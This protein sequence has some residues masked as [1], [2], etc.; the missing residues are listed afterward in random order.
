MR[1]ELICVEK[2]LLKLV[3]VFGGCVNLRSRLKASSPRLEHP[4]GSTPV[5]FSTS[6]NGSSYWVVFNSS[7]STPVTSS[8]SVSVSGLFS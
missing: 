6:V 1:F 3:F 2:K 4:S 7:V 8:A 5:T